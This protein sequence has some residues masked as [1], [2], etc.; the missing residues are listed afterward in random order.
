MSSE[1][2]AQTKKDDAEMDACVRLLM[3]SVTAFLT[4]KAELIIS[5]REHDSNSKSVIFSMSGA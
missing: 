5:P 4:G 3:A 2:E 1:Q